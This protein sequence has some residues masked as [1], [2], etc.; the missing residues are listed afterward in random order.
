METFMVLVSGR[1]DCPVWVAL[2]RRWVRLQT[3]SIPL[4]GGCKAGLEMSAVPCPL[5][6]QGRDQC[7]GWRIREEERKHRGYAGGKKIGKWSGKRKLVLV[8]VSP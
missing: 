3:I 2:E 7:E 8:R 4:D 5:H 1:L 6:R